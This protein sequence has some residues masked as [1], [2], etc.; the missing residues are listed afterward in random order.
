MCLPL[1]LP[2][3]Q[4]SRTTLQLVRLPA[5]AGAQAKRTQSGS[6]WQPM[7]ISCAGWMGLDGKC[8]SPKQT[9]KYASRYSRMQRRGLLSHNSFIYGGRRH[10]SWLTPCM[11]SL[12]C[13]GDSRCTL[14]GTG[15]S[16][17]AN[18]FVGMIILNGPSGDLQLVTLV[19][20][21]ALART[22]GVYLRTQHHLNH[23]A[24]S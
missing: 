3:S 13:L 16:Q 14:V 9:E 22:Y 24:T 23:V 20:L 21:I 8:A 11:P 2:L 1:C 12:G 19:A 5:Q 6:P 18:W 17:V 4:L 7:Q 15:A 10:K